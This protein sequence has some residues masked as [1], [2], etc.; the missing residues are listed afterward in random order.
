M[1]TLSY[2]HI[3]TFTCCSVPVKTFHQGLGKGC[4]SVSMTTNAKY[5]ATLSSGFPQVNDVLWCAMM[6][7]TGYYNAVRVLHTIPIS[8]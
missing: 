3:Y 5:I 6:F 4:A 7:S 8:T 2:A 1:T